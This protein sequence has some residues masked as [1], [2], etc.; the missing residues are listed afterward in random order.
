MY[1]LPPENEAGTLSG[2]KNA[3]QIPGLHSQ[4]LVGNGFLS[5][6]DSK[7]HIASHPNHPV[8]RH[9]NRALNGK[10]GGGRVTGHERARG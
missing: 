2:S 1:R 7:L 4:K 9:Q 8:T 5:G 3:N 10:G 6:A